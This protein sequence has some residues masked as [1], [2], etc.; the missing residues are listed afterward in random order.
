MNA[1]GWATMNGKLMRLSKSG[2]EAGLVR[3]GPPPQGPI[4]Q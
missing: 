2:D 4:R 1:D 3:L